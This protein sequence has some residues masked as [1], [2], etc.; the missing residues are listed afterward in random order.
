MRGTSPRMTA[1]VPNGD[2]LLPAHDGD[3]CKRAPAI[4]AAALGRAQVEVVMAGLGPATHVLLSS[5]RR[6]CAG[7]QRVYRM[8]AD[9]ASMR[10][11]LRV[12]TAMITRLDGTVSGLVQEVGAMHSWMARMEM[13]PNP[14]TSP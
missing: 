5:H 10:D 3:Y 12:Q 9:N 14:A 4:H 7:Y 8:M 1:I 11:E 13:E 2:A 6:G